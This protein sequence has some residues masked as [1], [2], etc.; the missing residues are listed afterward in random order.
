V[1]PSS[2]ACQ[3]SIYLGLRG[4]AFSTSDLGSSAEAAF[5]TA[6]ELVAMGEVDAAVAVGAEEKSE[7]AARYSGPVCSQIENRGRRGEGASAIVI[8][9]E[10]L[11]RARGARPI[12]RLEHAVALRG[13]AERALLERC[14]PG[15]PR[16]CARRAGATCRS[17]ASTIAPAITSRWAA[18]RWWSPSAP[19]RPA[20]IL[21]W[22]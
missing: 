16:R 19:S 11:A 1:L 22:C 10:A 21:R 13:S 7:I 2:P 17:T 6:A 5:V 9:H 4:P 14:S 12:A 8:E 15:A 18:S 3:A 20:S